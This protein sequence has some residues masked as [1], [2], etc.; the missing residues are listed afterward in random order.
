MSN[1]STSMS[2]SQQY[3]YPGYALFPFNPYSYPWYDFGPTFYPTYPNEGQINDMYSGYI[4]ENYFEHMQNQIN[5]G[6]VNSNNQMY[7]L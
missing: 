3:G 5:I 1:A 7:N 6:D 4:P 2:I